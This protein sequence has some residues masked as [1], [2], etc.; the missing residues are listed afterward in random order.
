LRPAAR[1]ED[2]EFPLHALGTGTIQ[3]ALNATQR[4]DL[5]IFLLGIDQG[6]DTFR[7]AADEFIDTLAQ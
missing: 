5:L 3:T 6:T 1:P 4:S 7:S 2:G